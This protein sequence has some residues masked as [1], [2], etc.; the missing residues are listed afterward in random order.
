LTHDSGGSW[1]E[2]VLHSFDGRDGFA[3]YGNL[4]F[5]SSGNLYGTA[6]Q[7]G[8]AG[9]GVAFKLTPN[10][11]GGWRET[12]LHSFRDHPVAILGAGLILDAKGNLYGTTTGD[13]NTTF[14][15][16]FEIQP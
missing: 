8:N 14:G 12:V 3:P 16:V 6:F 7:G 2:R 11:K 4:I 13:A 9:A 1:G 10:L 5:D 15:S